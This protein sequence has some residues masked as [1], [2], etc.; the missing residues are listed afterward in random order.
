MALV[1]DD[2]TPDFQ[3]RC[4]LA[5]FIQT[6]VDSATNLGDDLH[7]LEFT[8]LKAVSISGDTASAMIVGNFSGHAKSAY[9]I[10]A[11]FARESGRWKLAAAPDTQGCQSF[12]LASG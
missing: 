7:L 5:D 11:V 10:E 8:A 3:A 2:F 9:D 4:T 1:Y 6:G 12:N